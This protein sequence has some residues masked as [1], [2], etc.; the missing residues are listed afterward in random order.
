V[1][2]QGPRTQLVST[3]LVR[4]QRVRTQRVR[5][6]LVSR[7]PVT[8]S[9]APYA[10]PGRRSPTWS[11]EEL[12]HRALLELG[13]ALDVLADLGELVVVEQVGAVGGDAGDRDRVA[14][15]R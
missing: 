15:A 2:G 10:G 3:Q 12:V 6:Q 13:P 14:D 4:T 8:P 11:V 7:Q 9:E 5:T 1:G